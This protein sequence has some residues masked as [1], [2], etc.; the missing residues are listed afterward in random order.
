MKFHN[1]LVVFDLETSMCEEHYPI[2]IGAVYL[3]KDAEIVSSFDILINHPQAEII[4]ELTELTTITK[5]QLEKEGV[6]PEQGFQDFEDWVSAYSGGNT[7]KPRL[8]AWGTYFDSRV[9]RAEYKR[10][11]KDFAFAG[12][13][14]DVKSLAFLWCALSGHRTDKMSVETLFEQHMKMTKIPGHYHRANFDALIT[15]EIYRR[16]LKDLSEGFFLPSGQHV[17]LKVSES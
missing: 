2:E 14:I 7:K 13:F 11:N 9:V 5:E 3:N 16:I 4:P 8:A 15:A 12:T 1:D 6:T 17:S 10:Q